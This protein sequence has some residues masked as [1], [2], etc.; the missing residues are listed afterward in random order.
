[1][2][3]DRDLGAV[4]GFSGDAH[5]L[6]GA[7]HQLGNLEFE[8]PAHEVRMASADHDLGSLSLRTHLNDQSL[9]PV[10][11]FEPFVWDPLRAGHDG[12]G[13]AE[14]EDAVTLVDLLDDGS[15]QVAFPSGVD[16]VY[17]FPL[18]VPQPLLDH[19]LGSLG[20]DPSEIVGGVFPLPNHV[21]VLIQLLCIDNDVAA[22]GIDHNAGL[23]GGTGTAL[24]GG[25]QCIRQGIEDRFDG[26]PTF[27]LEQL[28]SL[29][30]H[31]IYTHM[32]PLLMPRLGGLFP[33][34]DRT[35]RHQVCK[36][37]LEP[38]QLSVQRE[39]LTVD[40]G[41]DPLHRRRPFHAAHL[42]NYLPPDR[43]GEMMG[44]SELAFQSR[45]RHLEL[46]WTEEFGIGVEEARQSLRDL[47]E[48][49]QIHP[50][51]AVDDYSQSSAASMPDQLQVVELQL[52]GRQIRTD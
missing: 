38:S 52:L 13:V 43:F 46:V 20:S 14:I 49:V 44:A 24:V 2:G 16:V 21:A 6:D 41:E 22:V 40:V 3:H 8:Q 15:D 7:V 32:F 25:D 9:D 39:T 36:L 45:R 10:P 35:R 17:L 23:F 29:H 37:D 48:A 27:P 33:T 34:E 50:A 5:D 18:G 28:E 42:G 26:H 12:F 19:L 1:M 47:R 51:G 11:T 4:T 30:D 31:C